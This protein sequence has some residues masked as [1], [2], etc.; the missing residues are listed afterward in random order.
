MKK[1]TTN[2]K[3]EKNEKNETDNVDYTETLHK[4]RPYVEWTESH[5][6]ILVD[7]AD[8]AL[9]YK[10]LHNKSHNEYSK[11]NT[12]FTIPVI[13]M[14]TLTGTANFAQDK[15]PAEYLSGATMA[16]GAVNLI[17]GILTTIQQ[18]LKITELNESHRVSSIAWG[19]FYRN[20]KIEISKSPIERSP[21]V[22]LLKHSKEEFDR[23]VETSPSLSNKV[24]KAFLDTFSG[25]ELNMNGEDAQLNKKQLNFRQIKKPDICGSIEP[26]FYSLYKRKE[27]L[28]VYQSNG[29]SQLE[30]DNNNNKII[31]ENFIEKFNSEKKRYPTKDEVIDNLDGSIHP[32]FINAIYSHAIHKN[33]IV[34]E[35][36]S[37]SIV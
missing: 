8:K 23:L 26:T 7:W 27:E 11:K 35:I 25:G 13:I 28:K 31:I 16:I 3:N 15:I 20:I 19:K 18:F 30:I 24:V 12:W 1:N 14:S 6:N 37:D 4:T 33:N 21:V 29:P 17:A 2:E 5:E 9:C 36:D 22:E 32:D 10:W 34:L